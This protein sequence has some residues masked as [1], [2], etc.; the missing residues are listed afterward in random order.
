MI[1]GAQAVT[2]I[3]AVLNFECLELHYLGSLYLKVLCSL[4]QKKICN[5]CF[6]LINS[7][8][9]MWVFCT[10]LV[11]QDFQWFIWFS[12]GTL[13][14]LQHHMQQ[15]CDAAL[16]I[17]GAWMFQQ[18]VLQ[19]FFCG[20]SPCRHIPH[21]QQWVSGAHDLVIGSPV[22]LPWGIFDRFS[23]WHTG[24]PPQVLPFFIVQPSQFGQLP[25]YT[26]AIH[27]D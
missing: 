18:F 17:R 27:V 13:T 20:I 23:P 1:S 22:L 16:L 3:L 26:L 19:K 12:R 25:L 6:V 7:T 14:G 4:L 10:N 5:N 11:I 8:C 9:K 15:H 21:A 2:S 24:N